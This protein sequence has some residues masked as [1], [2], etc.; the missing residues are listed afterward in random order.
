M[1]QPQRGGGA[2]AAD[3]ANDTWELYHSDVD[4]SEVHDPAAEHPDKVKELVNLWYVE[5][6]KYDVL[7]LYNR[8]VAEL[9]AT[10]PTAKIPEGGIYRYYSG[11][12]DVPEFDAAEIRGRSFKILASVDISDPKAQGVILAVGSR[13]G[14]HS[15]FLKED[16]LW[17]VY[18]FLGIPPEQVLMS[19]DSLAVGSHVVGSEFQ[20]EGHGDRA[21]ATGTALLHIDGIAV[22]KGPWKTQPGHFSL[23]GEGLSIGRDSAD[24]VS[25]EYNVFFPFVGGRIR[26][27]EISIG[28]DSYLRSRTRLP[29]RPRPRLRSRITT[30]LRGRSTR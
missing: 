1:G 9:V 23:C 25:K 27:V 13:F 8:S 3:Y 15:L 17:Y 5:A 30:R 18:N 16:K 2:T 24:P 26:H 28:D 11:T 14:G 10:M 20:K 6:G 7:P 21:E 4:R 22:A 19:P 12:L 29:G